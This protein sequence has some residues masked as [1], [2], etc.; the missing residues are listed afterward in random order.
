MS[1]NGKVITIFTPTYNRGYI[2]SA[3]YESL[4]MQIN[5]NF[6]WLIIDDVSS[7]DTYYLV[8]KWEEKRIIEIKY[9]YQKNAGKHVAHNKAVE[10]CSTDLFLCVDS[11]DILSNQAVDII[12]RK[13]NL[14]DKNTDIVGYCSRRGTLNGSPTGKNWI[15]DERKVSFFYLTEYHKFRGE[16]AL[17]WIT[18]I[19]KQYKFPI[20]KSEKFVTENVLYYQISY[21]K[22]MKLLNDV[23]YLFEYKS[24]GYTK[25]GDKLYYKNPYGFAI[26]RYQ[27]GVLSNK[28]VKKLRWLARYKGWIKAFDLNE[29]ILNNTLNKMRLPQYNIFIQILSYAYAIHYKKIYIRNMENIN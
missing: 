2:L 19:L 9:V 22:P 24:D 23:F 17:V 10:L 15:N 29:N 16:L 5:K 12:I 18:K 21:N 6:I 11:D 28:F 13:W 14:E 20:F 26:Y 27:S 1:A 25:Q 8:K 3:L 7:D 4:C